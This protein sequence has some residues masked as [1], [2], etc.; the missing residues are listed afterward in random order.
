M[1]NRDSRPRRFRDCEPIRRGH[2]ARAPQTN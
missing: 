1:G 2:L